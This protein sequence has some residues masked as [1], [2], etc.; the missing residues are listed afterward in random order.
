MKPKEMGLEA[1]T[2]EALNSSAVTS[3]RISI[4]LAAV[5]PAIKARAPSSHAAFAGF[6][7]GPAAREPVF[8]CVFD[9]PGTSVAA[10]EQERW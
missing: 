7:V 4:V 8:W 2:H 9:C 5:G 10:L 6:T 3:E 1:G